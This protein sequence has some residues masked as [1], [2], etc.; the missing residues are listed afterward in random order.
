[1]KRVLISTIAIFT[2][3]LTLFLLLALRGL[4]LTFSRNVVATLASEILGREVQ[5]EGPLIFK[6]STDSQLTLSG[7]RVANAEGAGPEPLMELA[8]LVVQV[9]TASLLDTPHI[10]LLHINGLKIRIQELVD[11]TTNIPNML[12]GNERLEPTEEHF[13]T[14][15]VTLESI[16]ITDV[17]ASFKSTRSQR[18]LLFSIEEL[19]QQTQEDAGLTLHGQGFLDEEPWAFSGDYSDLSS[20]I[21][22]KNIHHSITGYI[23]GLDLQTQGTFPELANPKDWK[24]KLSINGKISKSLSTLS[25]LMTSGAQLNANLTIV[26]IDPGI[27]WQANITLDDMALTLNGKADDPLEF[28]DARI[29]LNAHGDNLSDFASV[30]GLG[31]LPPRSFSIAGMIIRQGSHFEIE[32]IVLRAGPDRLRLDGEFSRFPLTSDAR[33]I[34]H[35]S[36]PDFSIYQS[37]LQL[38]VTLT[39]PYTFSAQLIDQEQGLELAVSKLQLGE[40]FAAVQ[41]LIGDYPTFAGSDFTF[42]VDGPNLNQLGTAVGAPGMPSIA[43]KVTGKA[44]VQKEGNV[45]M[46]DFRAD[47]GDVSAF[48]SGET[49][50]LPT[51]DTLDFKVAVKAESLT[52]LGNIFGISGL[53]QKPVQFEATVLRELDELKLSDIAVQL[54]DSTL[55]SEGVITLTDTGPYGNLNTVINIPDLPNILGDLPLSGLAKGPYTLSMVSQFADGVATIGASEII[56]PGFKGTLSGHS[57]PDFAIAGMSLETK[58]NVKS[59]A[60][61]IP[62]AGDYQLP[63][64]PLVLHLTS[65]TTGASTTVTGILEGKGAHLDF[66]TLIPLKDNTAIS[67]ALAGSGS[68]LA[69]FGDYSNL[70]FSDVPYDVDVTATI[71]TGAYRA[72]VKKFIVGD[73][74]ITGEI[75]LQPNDIPR[76]EAAIN[77]PRADIK[78]WNNHVQRTENHSDKSTTPSAPKATTQKLIPNV[79]IPTAFL[80]EYTGDIRV[81]AGKMGIADPFF[82]QESLIDRM[83]IN[84]TLEKE[85]LDITLSELTGSRGKLSGNVKMEL[86]HN[87]P[88]TSLQLEVLDFPLGITASADAIQKLPVHSLTAQFSGTGSSLRDLLASINGELELHGGPGVVDDVGLNMAMES[89]TDQLLELLIP[90]LD[91]DPN[92]AV[93]CTVIALQ[94]NEGVVTLDPG[95]VMR[96][97]RMDMEAKGTI[98]L[99]TE[100]VRIQFSNK[101]RK[102]LGISASGLINPFIQIVGTLANPS[103]GIDAKGAT[104]AG[105]TAVATGGLSILGE[106]LF[107]RFLSQDKPCEEA[108]DRLDKINNEG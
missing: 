40:H 67:M 77:I 33:L 24:L 99:E 105:S 25:P 74:E 66:T 38:P 36:G 10:R 57:G 27:N 19:S 69:A 23:G 53:A 4:D 97:A 37:L 76:L 83:V 18:P 61:L 50:P 82:D 86:D 34:M 1:M 17:V 62:S 79:L 42:S 6:L 87:L 94:A 26:D 39:V 75:Y 12:S 80:S 63:S 28:D 11:G 54:A 106:K 47:I 98:D 93:K 31:D 55:V 104:I 15:P 46:R 2:I 65:S 102:G 9:T 108:R 51:P 14:V 60:A 22:G 103:V 90:T 64:T 29:S 35:V 5:I 72:L 78:Y 85:V 73:T 68:N 48:A 92:I 44:T 100:K 95:F 45:I 20:L 59:P 84:A 8:S 30:V 16:Q 56:G 81:T 58:F 21:T 41:G 89:F 43:Y 49:S 13:S 32:E 3:I 7:I 71:E 88:V 107:D 52:D 70:P 101:A 96:T 91:A